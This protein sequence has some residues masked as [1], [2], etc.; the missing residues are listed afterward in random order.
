MKKTK[1]EWCDA[2]WNPVT[3]CFHGCE[4][5]YARTIAYRFGLSYFP[6]LGD[7]GMEGAAKYDSEEEGQ[8]TMLEI[9][10]P[11][12]RDGK[13]Q[14]YPYGFNPTF[15]KY[16]L[17]EIKR[18][19]KPRTIFVCSMA[20]LFGDWVPDNWIREVFTACLEAPQHKY[21]FLTK[22]FKKYR[23]LFTA[24]RLP[25]RANIFY[26]ITVTSRKEL[27]NAQIT[28]ST[29]PKEAM[30]IS[31]EPLLNNIVEDLDSIIISR[32][33]GQII[34]GAETGHRKNRIVP[35]KQWIEEICAIAD[36]WGRKVFMK[37]S[38]IPIIGEENMRRELIWE[39]SNIE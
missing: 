19:T 18:W 14:P 10:K 1:I 25:I 32:I 34:I 3:G 28:L 39:S 23:Y 16:R 7:P 13:A 15:H 8:D 35:K 2:T 24:G 31:A 5:C 30:F 33:P 37:D 17:N 20:D 38:L 36:G 27:I 21:L 4:Y 29:L 26:G 12:M 6:K 9:I 22:N 11:Y